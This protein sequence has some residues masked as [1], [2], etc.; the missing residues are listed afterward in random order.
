MK[1]FYDLHSYVMVTFKNANKLFGLN[2]RSSGSRYQILCS[3]ISVHIIKIELYE[4]FKLTYFI[5]SIKDL[6]IF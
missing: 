3:L 5:F 6:F 4:C 1:C 2:W